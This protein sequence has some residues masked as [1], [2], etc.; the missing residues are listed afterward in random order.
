MHGHSE[1][2]A[3]QSC[4]PIST[5]DL[6]TESVLNIAGSAALP[7]TSLSSAST[8]GA[9]CYTEDIPDTQEAQK[10]LDATAALP[11]QHCDTSL[12]EG[13][14]TAALERALLSGSRA[15]V[16]SALRSGASTR[17]VVFGWCAPLTAAA[18]LGH[19]D[20]AACLIVAGADIEWCG[21]R[22]YLA[23]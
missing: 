1:A 16:Q 12:C 11:Q 9:I 6:A 18:A 13:G 2:E 15:G 22:R 19:V 10:A 20:V 8:Q 14:C 7:E 17:D 3:F 5:L 21:T 4:M 23:D